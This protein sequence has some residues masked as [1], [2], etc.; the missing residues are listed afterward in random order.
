M[1][2]DP[3]ICLID[4]VAIHTPG[5]AVDV[6]LQ[7]AIQAN[8]DDSNPVAPPQIVGTPHH[9]GLTPRL[10]LLISESDWL[11][12]LNLNIYYYYNY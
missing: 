5:N 10:T 1:N 12:D 6:A 4:G 11:P 8:Q 7:F 2:G 9:P 3:V